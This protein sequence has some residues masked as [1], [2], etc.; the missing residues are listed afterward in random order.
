MG[1]WEKSLQIVKCLRDHGKQS[2][3]RLAQKTGWS[4]S[5]VHRLQQARERRGGY[6][7][8]W[9]WET[10]EGRQWL[11]RLVLATL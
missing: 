7:E 2:V 6:P 4:K 3:R 10:A 9:L 8:S 11:P 5:R 1:F